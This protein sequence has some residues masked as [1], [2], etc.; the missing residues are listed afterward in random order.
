MLAYI[1]GMVT[2]VYNQF[3]FN[4]EIIIVSA[5]SPCALVCQSNEAGIL[6]VRSNMVTDGTPCYSG[7]FDHAVCIE[8]RCR[9][10]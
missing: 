3:C 2:I 1:D 8:R 10:S 4:A 6:V 9:V 7:T 5:V